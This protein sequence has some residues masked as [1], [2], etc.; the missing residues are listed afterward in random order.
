MWQN[1][2]RYA[3]EAG[4]TT[5]ILPEIS[6]RVD[7]PANYANNEDSVDLSLLFDVDDFIKAF[8]Q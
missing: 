2:V 7:D 6:I 5:F 4:A 3:I 8:R 1:C